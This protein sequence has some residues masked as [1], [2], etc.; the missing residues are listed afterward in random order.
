M[1]S[2]PFTSKL[3]RNLESELKERNDKIENTILE[4]GRAHINKNLAEEELDK[5]RGQEQNQRNHFSAE[6]REVDREMRNMG[7]FREFLK[8]KQGEHA[9]LRQ[10]EQEILDKRQ[11]IAQKEKA[12]RKILIDLKHTQEREKRVRKA[13]LEIQN[14]TGVKD[15]HALLKLFLELDE[16]AETLNIFVSELEREIA[17]L[18]EDIADKQDKAKLYEWRSRR[19]NRS[20]RRRHGQE[21]QET[22]TGQETG[23]GTVQ[24]Q[25]ARQATRTLGQSHSKG[26][27]GN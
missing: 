3:T 27:P 10:I 12:N 16:K 1:S 14:E 22:G 24:A 23:R 13:F 11:Q 26:G 18:E 9:K 7:R 17:K 21:R 4:A 25:S 15:S 6:K 20:Q 8:A 19:A 5:V 2:G